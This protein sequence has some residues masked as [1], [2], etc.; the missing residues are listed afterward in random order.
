MSLCHTT[1]RHRVGLSAL[2]LVL[3]LPFLLG[4]MALMVNIGNVACWK[5]RSLTVARQA[6]WGARW[7]RTGSSD[8]TPAY[9]PENANRRVIEAGNVTIDQAMGSLQNPP[10]L[11]DNDKLDPSRGLREGTAAVSRRFP[12]LRSLGSFTVQ[13]QDYLLDDKWQYQEMGIPTNT[14]RRS[15]TIYINIQQ[16]P[17]NV[18][19][20]YEQF[21]ASLNYLRTSLRPLDNDIEFIYYKWWLTGSIN[22]APDFHPRLQLP[23]PILDREDVKRPIADLIDHIQGKKDIPKVPSVAEI[24]TQD[25]IDLYQNVIDRL[26]RLKQTNPTQTAAIETAIAR[27]QA[28]IDTLNQ[29]LQTLQ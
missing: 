12:M 20:I 23:F 13:A 29:F 1:S 11:A 21:S 7:A 4:I 2:E 22:R 10:I 28:K 26:N 14:Y 6:V 8:P 9:W 5:V 3:A 25:F 24:M 19:T 27:F 15:P 18:D 17:S 16:I